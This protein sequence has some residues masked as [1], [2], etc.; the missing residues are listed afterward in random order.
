LIVE[1][2]ARMRRY[3]SALLDGSSYEVREAVTA[4]A[5]LAEA[6]GWSPSLIL[7]DLGLPDLDGLDL[8]ERL[9]A[10]GP[11]PIVVISARDREV[12]KVAALDLG[13]DDY[14]TKPFGAAELLARVRAHLRRGVHQDL[15]LGQPLQVGGLCI[16]SDA[17]TVTLDGRPITLTPT[18]Y[19][20]LSMLAR[21]A[22]RVLTHRQL[23]R[24]VWGPQCTHQDHYVRVYITHLRR[25]IEPDPAQPRLLLTEPGVGYRLA[26]PALSHE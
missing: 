20:L 15:S 13:A 19:R 8:I 12:D 18:E 11:V 3:L 14:L 10:Q 16:D 7:L 24:E 4:H 1:D 9:R 25:K 21:H 6:A 5:A 22:G 17:Y 23:L 26:L 2:E